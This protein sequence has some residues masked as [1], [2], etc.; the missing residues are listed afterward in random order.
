MDEGEVGVDHGGVQLEFFRMAMEEALNPD[1]GLFVT[2]PVTRMS[3]FQPCSQEPTYRFELLGLLVSLAIYNGVTLPV[4]FPLALYR[5][6]LGLQVDGLS[7]IRDGWVSLCKG[8]TE[9]RDWTD[10]DVGDVFLR[11][12]EFGTE[13]WGVPLYHDMTAV[14]GET[15]GSCK[16]KSVKRDNQDA[17]KSESRKRSFIKSPSAGATESR[18]VTNRNRE[19]YI[20]DYISWLTDISIRPQYEAF[21]RGFSTCFEARTLSVCV[22]SLHAP[23]SLN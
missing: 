6:I 9:L 1:H 7:H 10:G 4:T 17:G 13:A 19:Q 15:N 21:A 2:D 22:T 12:Y 5:K 20:R 16:G 8:L 18:L 14:N 3:W 11:T 23:V